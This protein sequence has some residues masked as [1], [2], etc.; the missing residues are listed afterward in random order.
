MFP[1]HSMEDGELRQRWSA[2]GT[3]SLG[4]PKAAP[5]EGRRLPQT[6]IATTAQLSSLPFRVTAELIY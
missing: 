3:H 1:L 2:G 5:L 6:E 4:K